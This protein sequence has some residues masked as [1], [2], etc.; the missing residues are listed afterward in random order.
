[1][2]FILYG[3]DKIFQAESFNS[4]VQL[5]HHCLSHEIEGDEFPINQS[6]FLAFQV[7]VTVLFQFIQVLLSGL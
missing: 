1:M 3:L 7:R 6:Q 2:F 4:K 5:H